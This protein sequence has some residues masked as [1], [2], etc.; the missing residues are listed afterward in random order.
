LPITA[1]HNLL[2]SGNKGSKRNFSQLLFRLWPYWPIALITL[3]TA[4]I[5]SFIYLRSAT[6]YYAANAQIVVNDNSLEKDNSLR[7]SNENRDEQFQESEIEKQIEIIKSNALLAEVTNRLKLNI[8]I[9]D[10]DTFEPEMPLSNSLFSI[11]LLEAGSVKKE[12]EGRVKIFASKNEIEFNGQLYPADTAVNTP[13]GMVKWTITDKGIPESRIIYIK[14]LPFSESVKQLE[15]RFSVS[16]LSKQSAILELSIIDEIPERAETILKTII[17]AYGDAN[18]I[19]KKKLLEG[20]LSFID[21]RLQLVSTELKGV[22]TSLR[23]YK[24]RGGITDLASEGQL[25]LGQVRENDQ[26]LSEI[27]VQLNVLQEIQTYLSER[28][29]IAGS[30]PATLGLSDQ[31]LVTLLSQL[32]QDEFDLEKLEKLSGEKNSQV[33]I[34]KDRIEKR[35]S[36]ILESVGNLV[37]SLRASRQAL[38]A[39]NSTY[40]RSLR[41]IPEKERTL[42]NITRDQGI[43]ND[44][45]TFLLRKREETAIAAA[46]IAPGYKI[47]ENPSS[48]GPVKPNPMLIYT[49]GVFAA[50]LLSG[51]WIYKKEFANSRI[52]YKSEI[53]NNTDLP[54]I[55]EIIFEPSPVEDNTELVIGRESRTLIAEQFREIRTNINYILQSEPS[56]RVLMTTSS[57]PGEGKSF[58]SINLAASF[59]FSGKRTALVEFDLYKPKVCEGLGV[60]YSIGIT[61]FLLE[62]TT[63]EKI[64]QPYIKIPNL[65]VIPAGKILPNPAELIL[66]GKVP[67]LMA[68]LK[69]E[70]DYIIIDSPAIG[71]VSDTKILAPYANLSLYII[72][73][74]YAHHGFLKFINDLN[75]AGSMPNIHLI[76]NGIMIRKAPGLDYWDSYGH[77]GYRYG[78]N[79]PY[80]MAENKKKKRKLKLSYLAGSVNDKTGNG[81]S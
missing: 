5:V 38:L 74:K 63:V 76:F 34:L 11:E 6:K 27:D 17:E 45:Y 61:D 52:L 3:I 13:L 35:K 1:N 73:Q 79:N 8:Q 77:N 78:N 56:G 81:S 36:S 31:V 16:Q 59:A 30:P 68:Y 25:Y 18:Q 50:L 12:I 10:D 49:Y 46:A 55:G 37:K 24:S 75:D 26:R 48:T 69:S 39:N 29:Q 47:I 53:E 22:E 64:C 44:L 14:V 20:T 51:L 32:F 70:F 21:E 2:D 4:I 41:S 23:D 57:V 66:N 62:E 60:S 9:S 40:N 71:M 28:N 33:I 19:D 7:I 65:W 42:L 80:T 72:R 58:V 54:V 15:E 43:K 67:D